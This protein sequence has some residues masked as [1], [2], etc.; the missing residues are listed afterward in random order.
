ML[1]RSLLSAS[2]LLILVAGAIGQTNEQQGTGA[3]GGSDSAAVGSGDAP[4]STKENASDSTVN[5]ETA[6]STDTK[7][8]PKPKGK[9][10]ADGAQPADAS[11]VAQSPKS[12]KA[13]QSTDT[14]DAAQ[15]SE[16]TKPATANETSKE[17][18]QGTTSGATTTAVTTQAQSGQNG[19]GNGDAEEEG[20]EEYRS[21]HVSVDKPIVLKWSGDLNPAGACEVD[22]GVYCRNIKYGEQRVLRCL[23]MQMVRQWDGDDDGVITAGCME[24]MVTYKLHH[25]Q[26]INGDIELAKAC[27]KDAENL[28]QNP[29]RYQGSGQGGAVVACLRVQEK[30]VSPGCQQELF[31]IIREAAYDF[32]LDAALH[33][34]CADEVSKH[35]PKTPPGEGRVVEC[36]HKAAFHEMENEECKKEVLRQLRETSGDIRLNHQ[37]YQACNYEM[38][39]FC[40]GI[41]PGQQKMQICLAESRDEEGFSTKCNAAVVELLS[42]LIE[43]VQ[44]DEVLTEGCAEDLKTLCDFDETN[45]NADHGELLACL[46]KNKEKLHKSC[47]GEVSRLL[48]EQFRNINLNP[49]LQGACGTDIQTHCP[50]TVQDEGLTVECLVKKRDNLTD[51]C[52]KLLFEQRI[53]RNQSIA[54]NMV[55]KKAC[56]K[57]QQTF[58][59]NV[60]PGEGR[61][62]Q[63]LMQNFDDEKMTMNCK[64]ALSGLAKD[65]AEDYRLDPQLEKACR[66][67]AVALCKGVCDAG[68]GKESCDGKVIACL[69]YNTLQEEGR[70][71]VG[72]ADEDPVNPDSQVSE[73]CQRA[74]N[75]RTRMQAADFR[76][77][78]VLA[79]ACHEDAQKLCLSGDNP[80]KPGMGRIF[81]C[82]FERFPDLSEACQAEELKFKIVQSES[83]QRLPHLFKVCQME[84]AY[85]CSKVTPTG[86]HVLKCLENNVESSP[87]HYTP[88]CKAALSNRAKNLQKDYRFDEGL[89]KHCKAVAKKYKC[90]AMKPQNM[91]NGKIFMCLVE[92]YNELLDNQRDSRC[93]GEMSRVVRQLF[94]HYQKGAPVTNV[95]DADL[96]TICATMEEKVGRH[97]GRYTRCLGDYLKKHENMPSQQCDKLVAVG[98]STGGTENGQSIKNEQLLKQQIEA[99]KAQQKHIEDRLLSLSN[100]LKAAQDENTATSKENAMDKNTL[101]GVVAL[102]GVLLLAAI[103]GAVW[104]VRK[105]L[106]KGYMVLKSG[107]V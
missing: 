90:P 43:D 83:V 100:Q 55:L 25:T 5:G 59:K 13:K 31:R 65:E 105:Y 51:A 44:E 23:T 37:L 20:G 8:V 106:N 101:V 35:C 64:K 71:D 87:G 21:D 32:R 15:T 78:E 75:F 85:F 52:G 42:H 86:G 79:D 28:C 19:S 63:C 95:C 82:L 30:S 104:A 7:V 77:N 102:F 98:K 89:H 60:E 61:V 96:E 45:E 39:K 80:V 88:E 97:S 73:E 34:K 70:M 6:Q 38:Q 29:E 1:K 46:S 18:S 36:L 103:V 17:K 57:D 4:E 54:Y 50:D 47:I 9:V 27:S 76:N 33:A 72:V 91:S 22:K 12:V 68:D 107:D 84:T 69:E 11:N 26:S 48:E 3:A 10:N 67:D 94:F 62:T 14:T 40:H 93:A 74:L 56:A 66:A 99:S 53:V 24:E 2:L 41:Q 92:H 49:K 16:A 81:D 58:C